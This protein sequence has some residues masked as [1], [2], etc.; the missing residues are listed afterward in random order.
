MM[1]NTPLIDAWRLIQTENNAVL[2]GRVSGRPRTP[3][4]AIVVTSPVTQL[5]EGVGTAITRSSSVYR[6]GTPWPADEALP[7][8]YRRAL[9][10]KMAAAGGGAL[11]ESRLAAITAVAARCCRP[12]ARVDEAILARLR[13]VIM[14]WDEVHLRTP[15][16]TDAKN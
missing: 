3:D 12:G 8:G 7:D 10:Q 15:W 14:S 9:I 13:P 2:I 4:G 1:T 5:D 6:L 11:T 16:E